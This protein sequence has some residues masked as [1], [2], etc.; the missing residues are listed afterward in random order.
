MYREQLDALMSTIYILDMFYIPPMS[1]CKTTWLPSLGT[2]SF[3]A[4]TSRTITQSIYLPRA[5][6]YPKLWDGN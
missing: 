1:V 4:Y 6:E 5:E 3:I 2:L